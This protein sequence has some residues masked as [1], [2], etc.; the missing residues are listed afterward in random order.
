[1]LEI[2]TS[3]H[4]YEIRELGLQRNSACELQT[5]ADKR[6]RDSVRGDTTGTR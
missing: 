6:S 3:R 5:S 1:M 4:L 2:D